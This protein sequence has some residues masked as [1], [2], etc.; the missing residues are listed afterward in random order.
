M[1]NVHVYLGVYYLILVEIKNFA[2]ENRKCQLI[3]LPK[4]KVVL[5]GDLDCIPMP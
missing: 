2:R 4:F 5:R 1:S 3:I